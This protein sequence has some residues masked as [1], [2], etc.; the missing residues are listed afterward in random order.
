MASVFPCRSHVK[1]MA[2]TFLQG[3]RCVVASPHSICPRVVAA[4]FIKAPARRWPV[5]RV[6]ARG[7]HSKPFQAPIAPHGT[8]WT[9]VCHGMQDTLLYCTICR[10]SSVVSFSHGMYF[11]DSIMSCSE[12]V[13]YPLSTCSCPSVAE[14]G[15][16][17]QNKPLPH[18]PSSAGARPKSC[19]ARPSRRAP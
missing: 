5:Q 10:R 16:S 1:Q 2:T 13:A 12:H 18:A 8:S 7:H 9:T 6:P 4:P 11:Y 19:T 17:A 14:K 3:V 15:S